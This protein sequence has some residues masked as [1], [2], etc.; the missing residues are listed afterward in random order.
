MTGVREV[1]VGEVAVVS[2]A[3]LILILIGFDGLG[4]GSMDGRMAR[5]D[6]HCIYGREVHSLASMLRTHAML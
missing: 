1:G 5:C 4:I 3:S 2:S 6:E